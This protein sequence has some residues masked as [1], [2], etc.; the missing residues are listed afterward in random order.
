MA[1]DLLQGISATSN[2]AI[3]FKSQI[4]TEQ[5]KLQTEILKILQ[6]KATLE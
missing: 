3:E 5:Q 2:K 4:Q 1:T 6:H